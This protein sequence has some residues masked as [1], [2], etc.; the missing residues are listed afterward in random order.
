MRA[1]SIVPS[2]GRIYFLLMSE[3]CFL[4]SEIRSRLARVL[5]ASVSPLTIRLK[6][7][8]GNLESMQRRPASVLRTASTL[9][10]DLKE[11]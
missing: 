3:M 1:K 11:Y 7:S 5:S 4:T 10:P 2:S 9:T 6:F 8:M